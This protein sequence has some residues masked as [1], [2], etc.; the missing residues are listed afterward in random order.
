MEILVGQEAHSLRDHLLGSED[1]RGIEHGCADVLMCQAR[2]A[3][4]KFHFGHPAAQLGQ[5]ML[6]GDPSPLEYRFTR[7][8]IGLLF[9]E[10]LP[11]Q[12][13][14]ST[15]DCIASLPGRVTGMGFFGRRLCWLS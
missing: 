11:L 3:A 4:K 8:H 9:D 14:T 15:S 10:V 13:V 12:G 6:H 1:S 7:H 2:V 5:D